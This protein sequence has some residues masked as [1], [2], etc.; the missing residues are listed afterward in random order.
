MRR[1]RSRHVPP[2]TLASGSVTFQIGSMTV[3]AVEPRDAVGMSGSAGVGRDGARPGVPRCR[4]MPTTCHVGPEASLFEASV[5]PHR[6]F[7][8]SPEQL[9]GGVIEVA[10]VGEKY[11]FAGGTLPPRDHSAD[12]CQR[13]AH[14][15]VLAA[16]LVDHRE[17]RDLSHLV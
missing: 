17:C 1:R 8:A 11:A 10:A 12:G 15:E 13:G 7:L 3:L 4:F 2:A 6:V 9:P 5:E 16:H 14:V